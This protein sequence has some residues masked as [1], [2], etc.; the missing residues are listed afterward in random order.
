MKLAFS[1]E[2]S[3]LHVA[4][5]EEVAL[6]STILG[7]KQDK[8]MFAVTGA[9][10]KT[11]IAVVQ[12]LARRGVQIR[13]L[14]H[15]D[16]DQSKVLAAGAQEAIVGNLAEAAT[17]EK[18]LDGVRALY[19]ICPNMHPD[20][21][22]I[23]TTALACAKAAGLRHF[24]YHSVLHP[25]TE[26][27][28]HHWQ[29]MFVEDRIF[30]SGLSFTILQP[31][32]YMQNLLAYSQVIWQTGSFRVPYP[33]TTGLSLVD[34]NDVAEAATRVLTEPGHEGAT[35]ELVG[36]APL[37]HVEV[38]EVISAQMGSPVAAAELPLDE[39]EQQARKQGLQEYAVQTLLKMFRYYA[40]Y[41]LVGNPQVLRWLLGRE[42]TSLE[43]FVQQNM[44]Q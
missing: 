9:G 35:Y 28:P 38:A 14:V 10:G 26:A 24:V 36:S 18:F 16:S 3:F 42:P 44:V 39:W 29:K 34:V 15:K 21:V 32:A 4:K 22:A 13:G 33:I 43:A 6:P 1:Q 30:A 25:Q 23:G 2:L 11:G 37:T 41:G 12:A 5:F 20:E 8:T 7:V 17:L 40:A 19:H 27:M 31:T